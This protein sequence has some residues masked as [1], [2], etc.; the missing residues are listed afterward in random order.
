MAC[1]ITEERKKR[2][3]IADLLTIR[4]SLRT[5]YKSRAVKPIFNDALVAEQ[6]STAADGQCSSYMVGGMEELT[7]DF[8]TSKILF[9][10][11]LK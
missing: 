2:V 11:R 4:Y 5:F 8:A 7:D 1:E 9:Y 3:V 6:C 10:D